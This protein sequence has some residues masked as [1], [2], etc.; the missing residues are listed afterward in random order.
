MRGIST[1]Y[2]VCVTLS[3]KMDGTARDAETGKD[4]ACGWANN[5][6]VLHMHPARHYRGRLVSMACPAAIS[7]T[8]TRGAPPDA[9]TATNGS[10]SKLPEV[11]WWQDEGLL[12]EEC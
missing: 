4:G 8:S 1:L 6:T 2:C 3:L 5:Y 9:M 11:A 7:E 12:G 10:P